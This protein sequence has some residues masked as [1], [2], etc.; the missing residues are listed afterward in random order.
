MTEHPHH[1][2]ADRAA[3]GQRG[4]WGRMRDEHPSPAEPRDDSAGTDLP[5]DP[6][7]I[8]ARRRAVRGISLALISLGILLG[9]SLGTTGE[10]LLGSLGLLPAIL[11]GAGFLAV[12]LGVPASLRL[13]AHERRRGRAV[14]LAPTAVLGLAIAF[15]LAAFWTDAA[16]P[17]AGS[18]WTIVWLVSAA[19]LVTF[20]G[21]GFGLVAAARLTVPDDD[22]APLRRVDWTEEY[23]ER[24]VGEDRR[25]PEADGYDSAW[26]RG[27]RR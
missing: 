10:P 11:G 3:P 15:L 16:S 4:P 8:R 14:W 17:E 25:P 6:P 26:I 21:L 13:P 9:A 19:T 1:D 27:Q 5:A 20:A 22:D 7:P 24:F 23:P 12:A 2:P 18:P